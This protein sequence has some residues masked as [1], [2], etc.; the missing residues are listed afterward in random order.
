MINITEYHIHI[1]SSTIVINGRADRSFYHSVTSTKGGIA[2]AS[3]CLQVFL[4]VRLLRRRLSSIVSVAPRVDDPPRYY[5]LPTNETARLSRGPA[6]LTAFCC[7]R[8][9]RRFHQF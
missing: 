8:R 2:A 1:S 3:I 4:R 7:G 6:D 5:D 9:H